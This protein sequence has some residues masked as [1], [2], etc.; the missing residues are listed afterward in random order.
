MLNRRNL[1]WLIPLLIIVTFP[2]WRVPLSA[3]LTPRG[4]EAPDFSGDREDLHN[5]AMDQVII[6]QNK[7]GKKTAQI[8][9]EQAFTSEKSNE[10]VLTV[11]NADLFGDDDETV[12]I[13][14]RSGLYN[15]ET[16]QLTLEGNV[17]VNRTGT[18]QQLFS[19]LLY[20]YDESRTIRSP[21]D[22][23]IIADQLEL[24]GS[25]LDYDIATSKYKIGGRVYGT[26]TDFNNP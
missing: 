17:R 12:N 10:F 20:Y 2:A 19:E 14:A 4:G 13:K 25:S 21:V 18:D 26:I 6:T 22:T 9:A 7:M 3:F 24:K 5:F 16:R 23:R 1:L 8:E 15:T 11:V